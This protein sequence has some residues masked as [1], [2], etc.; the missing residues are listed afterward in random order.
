MMRRNANITSNWIVQFLVILFFSVAFVGPIVAVKAES[1]DGQLPRSKD[2]RELNFDF[3]EGNLRD[4][5]AEGDAFQAQPVRGDTV[6]SRRG[7]M[8]SRHA[9]D[10]WIGGF[11]PE[12]SDRAQ[13][14]LTS[15]PFRVTQPYASFLV[16][17]GPHESTRV[18]LADAQTGKPFFAV[19]GR[20]TENM[21]RAVVDLNSH[22]GKEVFVRI[23][24]D[25]SGHWG[26][27]NFDDFRLHKVKPEPES[28]ELSQVADA[29]DVY[30]HAGL[31]PEE[32][33][34]AMTVPPGFRVVL[35]AGEPDIHQP[36][37]M[38]MDDRGRL[39]IAEAYTYP[40]RAPEGEGKDRIV[41]FED[42]DG[43]GKFDSRKLFTEGL[44][45]VSGL[46]VGFGGVWVGA[47]PYL[48]FIPDEDGDDK[49]DGE[50]EI[51]L[52]GWGYHD[53][54]ETLNSFI[55][56]PDGW[57]YGCHGVF[58]H[59]LV[60]RPGTPDN[61]R[62]AINAGIWRYHPTR[63]EFDVFCHGTS[64]PWGMDF[65]DYGQAFLTTCVIPHL[66]HVIQGARYDRQAGSHFNPYTFDDIKTI[67]KHRHYVGATPHSG[68]N[69][70]DEA[71]GGHAHSGAMIYLG[72]TWPEKYRNQIF[73]NNIHGQRINMDV[74]AAGG[75]GYV[76]DRAPDFL[77]SNDRWS[78][79]LNLRYGPDGNVF[80]IDWYD[81]N[82]C[83]HGN[84]DGHDRT[85]GRVFK[86]VFGE[87]SQAP[88]N[89]KAKSGQELVDLQ[90]HE[91]DWHVR[92][93][94]RV[95]QERAD[96]G[97][98]SSVIREK[99]D[100][101]A[102]RHADA[103]R[104]LRGLWALHVTGGL[105]DEVLLAALDDANEY[106]RAWA[107]QLALDG[108]EGSLPE[109]LR[110]AL[111]RLAGQDSSQ[112]VRLYLAS[113]AQRL[114]IADELRWNIVSA[115][116]SHPED[117]SDHN[118]PLMYWYALEPM[119]GER[120]LKALELSAASPISLLLSYTTRR[121]ASEA[122]VKSLQVVFNALLENDH[123]QRQLVMLT[124]V[125]TALAG[126]RRVEAPDSWN[127]VRR[128]LERQGDNQVNR[129]LASLAVIFGDNSAM[130]AMREIAQ[131]STAATSTR[132]QALKSL[133][134]VRDPDFGPVLLKLIADPELRFDAI[135]AL[136]A[137]DIPRA[138]DLLLDSYP[139][140]SA[141]EKRAALATLAS[142]PAYAKRLLESVGNER[143]SA[144]EL[145]ADLVRQ[146]KNLRD[147][148]VNRLISEF[149]GSIRH[150]AA[151]KAELI[152]E[153]RW[154]LNSR[155]DYVPDLSMGRAVFA[156]NCQQCHTLFGTGGKVGPD[157]TGS[158]RA[159][160]NYI[161]TNIVDPSAVM[162]K[163][164][165]SNVVVTTDGRVIT[166]IIKSESDDTLTVQTPDQIVTLPAGE[167]DEVYP[168]ETSM[169]PDNLLQPLNDEQVRSLIA[170]LASS[171]QVPLYA[172][173][174]NQADF[175]NGKDLTGWH[176]D[177]SL[178]SVEDGELVGRT[179]GL[180]HN[181]FLKSDYILR[182]FRLTLKV[183]LVEN[184]GNS[185]IQF[186]S[187]ELPGGEV[188]GYQADIGAGW[189]GKLYEEHGRALLWDH[190]GEEYVKHGEWND[191]EI[192]AEGSHIRTYLNGH[193]CVDLNDP[194]GARQGI[195]ALQLHSGGATEVRF[196]D[197][198]LEV[199]SN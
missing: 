58:T 198:Q 79:I 32:A 120:P 189:W 19:S 73:M 108:R 71:G 119:A 143:I 180:G 157:L 146:L 199:K 113:A 103:T 65:D 121:V 51:L 118:L 111:V 50:P 48:L 60:G 90:L 168:S 177:E 192:V 44:N 109:K 194:D 78:Q 156:K 186:R 141:R 42:M 105:V 115:L 116:I 15:V 7:D 182:D 96:R 64:N 99:L 150:T 30:E 170:Y 46:E 83:H 91:N 162:A 70:S 39:W 17:G 171:G 100:E 35:S 122:D 74:L 2:G 9:G 114:P 16:G 117:A 41:I 95:L 181:E 82:A 184:E 140:F 45:L 92:H 145:P 89:M 33:A 155:P 37:A 86:V 153:Y 197:F 154:L 161:L 106:I 110:A 87:G 191:Y 53:T 187:D 179:A 196:K 76:G 12:K 185:G 56:G 43:D 190:S 151:D 164:Y 8:Q 26:H 36:I 112:A 11:E 130:E 97:E 175:F 125:E 129:Q 123:P 158:N 101:L 18:E 160:R 147:D 21:H 5:T 4:W 31:L 72:G 134:D 40:R 148:E 81:E 166:G 142:R 98:L 178:W 173:A 10:Y 61:E 176:G 93:A 152:S 124:A 149:W 62:A 104:R 47:A 102:T 167:V 136:A 68:N 77:L 55:W 94:R 133:V 34:E 165:M 195:V 57:L 139:D 85:N 183:K 144:S 66:F 3:E 131:D 28:P 49:P 24:D 69:R 163:E 172:A 188:K 52:D 1:P 132:R 137:Y 159:D 14:T 126:R 13:G 127:K 23:V 22:L 80:M 135:G 67:A 63:H 20:E 54:H 128:E 59:S 27:I 193:P 29:L 25:H 75:S 88:V 38:A 6:A 84:P 107:I 169:M 174:E 138:A